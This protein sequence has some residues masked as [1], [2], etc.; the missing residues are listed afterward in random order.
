MESSIVKSIKTKGSTPILLEGNIKCTTSE[1]MYCYS[2]SPGM[3]RT[4]HLLVLAA[5]PLV[6]WEE[7]V[8]TYSLD[9]ISLMALLYQR[10]ERRFF[11][12]Q[13][14]IMRKCLVLCT[15]V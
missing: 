2:G 15:I 1:E 13:F 7:M 6:L 3:K 11:L 5:K 12:R 14:W 10:A 8:H 9:L 4:Q